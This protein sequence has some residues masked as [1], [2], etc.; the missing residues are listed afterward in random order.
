MKCAVLRV[1]ANVSIGCRTSDQA[2]LATADLSAAFCAK[3]DRKIS[4][5]EGFATF[6]KSCSILRSAKLASSRPRLRAPSGHRLCRSLSEMPSSAQNRF[7]DASL[8]P[9]V[10]ARLANSS[11]MQSRSRSTLMPIHAWVLLAT[12]RRRPKNSRGSERR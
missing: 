11:A 9:L 5:I 1:L 2:K 6:L 4:A 3:R 10:A 12:K 8:Q 7:N